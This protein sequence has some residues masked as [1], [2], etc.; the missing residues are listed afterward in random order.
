MISSS[1]QKQYDGAV[2]FFFVFF[3]FYRFAKK[4]CFAGS[5]T[6]YL[7]ELSSSS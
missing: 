6:S 1:E 3:V 4:N 5:P 7:D 2:F